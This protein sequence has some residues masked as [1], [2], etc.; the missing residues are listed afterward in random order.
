MTVHVTLE[1]TEDQKTRLDELAKWQ[2]AR[3]ETIVLDA[4]ERMLDYDNWY[5]KQVQEGLDE[6]DR[7]EGIPHEQV[8]AEM[9]DL[10]AELLAG[11]RAV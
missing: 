5:R 6:L 7:G 2:D 1:L 8:V 10:R 11:K 3:V 4:V 9:A